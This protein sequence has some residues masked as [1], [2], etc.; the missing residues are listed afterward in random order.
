MLL[1]FIRKEIRDHLL[2][3]RFIILFLLCVIL[4]PT[5]FY[6]SSKNYQAYL[7]EYSELARTYEEQIQRATDSDIFAG[8]FL[9]KGFRP[10]A[11]LSLFAARIEE[12]LPRYF[13]ITETGLQPVKSSALRGTLLSLF[14]RVDFLFIIQYIFSLVA[15]LLAYDLISGEKELA[16][17]SFTLSNAIPRD[18]L[19]LG[20]VLGG[21]LTLLIPYIVSLLI[22]FLVLGFLAPHIWNRSHLPRMII[23]LL[24]SFVYL[25][26]FFNLGLVV[27]ART[28]T[29][30]TALIYC[31]LLW[32][33]LVLLYPKLG[34]V[35][36][37][38]AYPIRTQTVVG[39]Q[40]ASM[41]ASLQLEKNKRLTHIFMKY[42]G[43]DINAVS[44]MTREERA[45]ARQGYSR[46][47]APVEREF[48]EKINEALRKIEEQYER[49]KENQERLA[50][51]LSR[52]SPVGWI[53]FLI[54]N[55]AQVGEVDK[56]RLFS[57]AREYESVIRS[58][59]FSKFRRATIIY[60]DGNTLGMG[61]FSGRINVKGLP[62]FSFRPSSL[63]SVAK[64]M[65]VDGLLLLSCAVALFM[66]AHLSFLRYDVR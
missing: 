38:I 39:M 25:A 48:D 51:F 40:K 17:L 61:G 10:P 30:K 52:L 9:I 53:T 33:I 58:L 59:V 50:V 32:I 8:L 41:R 35:V 18:V 26:V 66:I 5:A 42:Y 28:M 21:Y 6:M 37:E 55:A 1:T 43:E 3:Q 60:P 45:V 56:R 23:I 7:R 47:S 24:G 63:S 16:T 64:E 29:S 36:A 12:I 46:E 11:P 14:G 57:S 54:A 31:F 20:K 62:R 22:G 13:I 27:S 4:M 2:S 44:K 15:I 65:A 34:A 49:E 19:L